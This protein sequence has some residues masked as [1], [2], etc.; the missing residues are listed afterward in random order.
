MRKYTRRF[1]ATYLTTILI[2]LFTIPRQVALAQ[3]DLFHSNTVQ[4]HP[5]N[6]D[7]EQGKIGQLPE[8]WD[9][10]TTGYVA[11]LID[12][13]AKSGKRAALLHDVPGAVNSSPFG[14]LMQAINAVSLRGHRVRF[15]AAVRTEDGDSE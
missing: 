11:K 5:V 8:G 13:Q 6:L 1:L 14:N 15:R 2:C 12:D 7:F 9:S 4:P 10:P 3:A